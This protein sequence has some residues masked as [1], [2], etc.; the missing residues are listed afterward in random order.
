[1]AAAAEATRPEDV[2]GVPELDPRGTPRVTLDGRPRGRI[3]LRTAGAARGSW[4]VDGPSV[5]TFVPVM[6]G[7]ASGGGCI[8]TLQQAPGLGALAPVPATRDDVRRIEELGESLQELRYLYTYY[9]D[10]YTLRYYGLTIPCI[11]ITMTVAVLNAVWPDCEQSAL[12]KVLLSGLS[13]SAT[14]IVAALALFKLQSRMDVFSKCAQQLEGIISK[15]SFAA[16][17]DVAG[18][19]KRDG[20][21]HLISEINRQMLDIRTNAPPISMDL[22]ARG[23]AR[24]LELVGRD[25]V[26]LPAPAGPLGPPVAAARTASGPPLSL[27][28]SA[29][30]MVPR[31]RALERGG[32]GSAPAAS[33]QWTPTGAAGSA[34]PAG[35]QTHQPTAPPASSASAD[36]R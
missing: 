13:A 5:G 32:P 27:R 26:L 33:P 18:S 35:V 36:R 31:L 19:V 4:F 3:Q 20:A 6:T 7:G 16:R 12:R 17:Y 28:S 2:G 14:M 24:H 8:T 30:T 10:V 15:C 9:A 11:L 25:S 22:E 29:P 23:R 21:Q 34:G 1:M